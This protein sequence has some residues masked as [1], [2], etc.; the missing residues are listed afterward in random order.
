MEGRTSVDGIPV[1]DWDVQM[2]FAKLGFIEE[3]FRSS[4]DE[5]YEAMHLEPIG[6]QKKFAAGEEGLFQ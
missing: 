1:F 6:I 5:Y 4:S 2:V 3:G